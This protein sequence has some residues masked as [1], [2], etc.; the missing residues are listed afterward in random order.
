MASERFS[1]STAGPLR[2]GSTCLWGTH[3][4]CTGG[5][6]ESI[7][8]NTPPAG[9]RCSRPEEQLYTDFL[10]PDSL[11]LNLRQQSPGVS[12]CSPGGI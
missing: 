1:A 9:L 11:I 4:A 5:R 8:D 10:G 2:R 6:T 7:P 12:A 3:F